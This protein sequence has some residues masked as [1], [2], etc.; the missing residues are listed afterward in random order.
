MECNQSQSHGF[1]WQ[2]D[3]TI[4][5]FKLSIVKNDTEKY[6]IPC[7][8][9]MFDKEENISIKVSKT[10]T[11]DCGDIL[12]FYDIENKTTIILL[13]Y[14][15]IGN[16]KKIINIYE[17]DYNKELRDI[18]FGS[19]TKEEINNYVLLIKNIVKGKVINKDYLQI[20][21]E[22]QI[23]NNMYINIS[24]KV[25]NHNQRRV[26]CSIPHIDV[27]LIK[28]PHFIKYYSKLPLLRNVQILSEIISC[29]RIRKC[30]PK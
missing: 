5:V 23:R 11:I 27:L 29:P 22:L 12:R 4:K 14:E 2:Y 19:I 21:K 6:D 8:N 26:Q 18:L 28:Y 17:I 15:Q 25:D 3:I 1:Q 13:Q 7:K 24:P 20:K 16:T 30:K 9:N 10:N